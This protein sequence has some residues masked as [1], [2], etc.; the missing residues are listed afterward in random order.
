MTTAAVESLE[1]TAAQALHDV[2]DRLPKEVSSK[3]PE[4]APPR[5]AKTY[6]SAKRAVVAAGRRVEGFLRRSALLDNFEARVER[7]LDVAIVASAVAF[8]AVPYLP[9]LA[10]PAGAVLGRVVALLARP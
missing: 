9:S 8:V 2:V 5:V 7:S 1:R 4:V 3:L 6:R 10:A